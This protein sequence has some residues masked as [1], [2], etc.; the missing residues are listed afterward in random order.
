MGSLLEQNSALL[1]T[2][3]EKGRMNFSKEHDSDWADTVDNLVRIGASMYRELAKCEVKYSRCVKK[4]S[5]EE[6]RNILRA[7]LTCLRKKIKNF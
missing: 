6:K 7:R 5:P 2:Q 4:C 3:N 1:K